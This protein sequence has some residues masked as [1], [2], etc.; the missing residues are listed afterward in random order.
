MPEVAC[1]ICRIEFAEEDAQALGAFVLVRDGQK[2]YFDSKACKTAF[3]R[4]R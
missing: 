2:Y 3:E 4:K 1:P